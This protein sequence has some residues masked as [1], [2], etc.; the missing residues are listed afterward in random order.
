MN[1]LAHLYFTD[2]DPA[3]MIGNF[4]ADMIKNKE[5]HQMDNAIKR[6]V[7]LHRRIDSYTDQHPATRRVT[8]VLRPRHGKYAPV[9]SDVLFDYILAKHWSTYSDV[10]LEV[11]IRKMYRVISSNMD[12][13]PDRIKERVETMISGRF[14][15][16]SVSTEGLIYTFDKL[17][18]RTK[19]R[20]DFSSAIV[21]LEVHAPVIDSNFHILF[22]DLIK[23]L[24]K[25]ETNTLSSDDQS[26]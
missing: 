7:E 24:P 15:H 16:K 23:L 2:G 1:Y 19:F 9:V 3:M 8:A 5:Y 18:R 17:D 26:I 25:S 4:V 10:P 20:S 22:K 13:I 6:G 11:F 14:L 12:L 21:D